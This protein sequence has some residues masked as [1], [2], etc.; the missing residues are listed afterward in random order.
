MA[1]FTVLILG[2]TKNL[3]EGNFGL[4]RF[5]FVINWCLLT[6]NTPATD[7]VIVKRLFPVPGQLKD[8]FSKIAALDDHRGAREETYLSGQNVRKIQDLDK[9]PCQFDGLFRI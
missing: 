6:S 1:V 4:V 2:A 9:F 7:E 3:D 8:T 5:F